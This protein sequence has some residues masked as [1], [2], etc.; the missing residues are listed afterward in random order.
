MP[1]SVSVL[2]YEGDIW[3]V[4]MPENSELVQR[5]RSP[6][7]ALRYSFSST[8]L[9]TAALWSVPVSTSPS[10]MGFQK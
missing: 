9:P 6:L 8:L 1:D 10:M 3:Y 5:V 2:S 4:G 7:C